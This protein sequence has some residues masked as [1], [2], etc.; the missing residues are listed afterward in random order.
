[1]QLDRKKIGTYLY[2]TYFC[3]M[4]AARAAG[5]YEGQMFYNAIL[6][7]GMALFVFKI[8]VTRYTVPEYVIIAFLMAVSVIV[9]LHT[10][11]KGLIVC[12][13]TML[14]MK[15]IDKIRV[16]KAGTLIAGLCIFFK[17]FTGVFGLTKDVFYP[18]V[19]PGLGMMFRHS[20][21]YVH[22]NTL[23]MN[24][25]MLGM[26][27]IYVISVI[28]TKQKKDGL[29][30]LIIASVIVLGFNLYIF[31]YSGSRT[32]VLAL[33]VYLTVNLWFYMRRHCGIPEKTVCFAAYPVVCLIAIV[34]P[35][36][37][38]DKLFDM[39]DITVFNTR[40]SLA[41]YFW[42]NNSIS[43]WGIR[44]NN[45]DPLFKTYGIDMAQL[46][47]FFQLGIVAFV[48]VSVLTLGYIY[49]AVKKNLMAE[50]AVL[51]G[52]LFAGIWEPFLYNLGFKNF[53]WVFF[54]AML[55]S[56]TDAAYTDEISDSDI[57][58]D[59]A[60]GYKRKCVPGAITAG[61]IMIALIISAVI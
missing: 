50:L 14:G 32:G 37:L 30:R 22:P 35:H 21:G 41:K 52:M 39:I 40:L 60:V 26:M 28:L 47:L 13:A 6:V 48:T 43:L 45:P 31:V 44:L 53:I 9:Y 20:L 3:L 55:Y 25:L 49:F 12:F 27:L 2:I 7:I 5:M 58:G 46:Y 54:G 18:Q 16:L 11:E 38:P 33:I 34:M 4:V 15:G 42:A 24:V 8:I 36:V 23:H 56:L 10:G 17:I 59:D 29:S 57:S 19:R 61:R 1:M 51:M